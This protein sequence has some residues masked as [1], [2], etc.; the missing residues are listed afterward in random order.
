MIQAI[1]DSVAEHYLRL[2][3]RYQNYVK[4]RWA[5][6]FR[7]DRSQ[8]REGARVYRLNDLNKRLLPALQSQ[9]ADLETEVILL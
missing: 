3:N 7:L 6:Q 8:T 2:H 4:E 9:L 5:L 1:N